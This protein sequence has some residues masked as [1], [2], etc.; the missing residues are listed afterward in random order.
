ME[1]GRT[2]NLAT[3]AAGAGAGAS[4]FG[5]RLGGAFPCRLLVI[6]CSSSSSPRLRARGGGGESFSPLS[7]EKEAGGKPGATGSVMAWSS[8][9]LGMRRVSC[10]KAMVT[11]QVETGGRNPV[12]LIVRVRD[13]VTREQ[14][15]RAARSS[16]VNHHFTAA[17]G[18]MLL[19]LIILRRRA[20]RFF[21][22]GAF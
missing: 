10:G 22:V 8:S 1:G 15:C 20:R 14:G 16:P 13:H 3:A 4:F 9:S 19:R 2:E 5:A 21:I 11:K 7:L 12:L 18:N 17:G 6:S